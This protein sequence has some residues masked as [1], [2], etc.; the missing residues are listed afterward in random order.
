MTSFILPNQV[1][2]WIL[3][4]LLSMGVFH[5]SHVNSR[6]GEAIKPGTTMKASIIFS[7]VS[8][9]LFALGLY[10]AGLL[11][12][13]F[14]E[15]HQWI[16]LIMLFFVG[17]RMTIG[18]ITRKP[19]TITYDINHLPVLL[20]L[21]VARGINLVFAGIGIGFSEIPAG[22]ILITFAIMVWFISFSGLHYGKQF[23]ENT[24]KIAETIAGIALISIALINY[25]PL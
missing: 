3:P 24:G 1:I 16:V 20:A 2:V 21:A 6:H 10:L 13:R 19:Y 18:A 14:D 7:V 9:L 8:V 5:V 11:E 12:K 4:L 17:I 15:N 25:W 23:G 22:R